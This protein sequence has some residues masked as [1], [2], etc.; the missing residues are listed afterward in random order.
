MSQRI[1][2]LRDGMFDVD[3]SELGSGPPLLYLHGIWDASEA[4]FVAELG[5]KFTV[6]APR[7]PGFGAS[8]GE[9]HLFDVHD[10]I[11]YFLDLVDALGLDGLPLVGHCLGGMFAAELAAVQPRRFSKLVLIDA[12]GLWKSEHEV[13]DLFAMSPDELARAQFGSAG[14][15]REAPSSSETDE[16]RVERAVEKVR[17]MSAAARFLW[18]IP[19]RG[20]SRRIHR[21][22]APTLVVWGAEDGIV[23]P[24]YGADFQE[25]ITGARLEM[26][27]GTGHLPHIQQPERVSAL[28]KSFL[29]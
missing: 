14:H 15:T 20:L 23:P 25:L 5:K 4:D 12:F 13:P 2:S 1:V 7:L 3:L 19:N 8:T 10:A 29:A 9:H 11:Y 24:A 17:C 6:I 27:D 21:V 26:L 22:A 16:Q 28:V 18:P